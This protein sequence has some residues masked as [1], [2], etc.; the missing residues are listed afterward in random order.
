VLAWCRLRGGRRRLISAKVPDPAVQSSGRV[1]QREA[2]AIVA[3]AATGTAVNAGDVNQIPGDLHY[4]KVHLTGM[5]YGTAVRRAPRGVT[6]RY[7]PQQ[8]GTPAGRLGRNG[9]A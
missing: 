8:P 4:A 1:P 2:V 3:G 5:A 7:L 9:R 6:V